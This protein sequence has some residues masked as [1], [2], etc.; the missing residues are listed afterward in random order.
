M[1]LDL[2]AARSRRALLFGAA[3]SVAALAATPLRLRVAADRVSY[4]NDED[5][6]TVLSATSASSGSQ[7]RRVV[8]DAYP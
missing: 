1:D 8:R 2:S 4:V 5:N 3:A 7:V 6:E